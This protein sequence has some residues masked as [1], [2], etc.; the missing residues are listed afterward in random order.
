ME[1]DLL[2]AIY[3]APDDDEPRLVYADWLQER[4]DPRG[5]FI[6]LQLAGKDVD[7]QAALIAEHGPTWI[8]DLP[9]APHSVRWYRGFIGEGAPHPTAEPSDPRWRTLH[10]LVGAALLSDAVPLPA[11]RKLSI[12][13][14]GVSHLVALSRPLP[15]ETLAWD[16]RPSRGSGGLRRLGE[17]TVLPRLRRFESLDD[18]DFAGRM[19]AR[20]ARIVFS[21]PCVAAI[22]ELAV[23]N[24]LAHAHDWL[25]LE[26]LRTGPLRR[27]ELA[28]PGA[29]GWRLAL[30]RTG[31]RAWD[32]LEITAPPEPSQVWLRKSHR[33]FGEALFA[34]LAAFP[35]A[36]F[37]AARVSAAPGLWAPIERALANQVRL[38]E[39]VRV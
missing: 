7:R 8:G 10:A 18:H 22:E 17:V 1:A 2:A 31:S 9:I 25:A 35:R 32:A 37:I 21:W 6:T 27:L 24:D 11:L 26:A 12:G 15:V 30:S 19:R 23:F 33:P 34:G 4:G 38:S 3:A 5:E 28:E 39:I 13:N 29:F 14:E 16:S 20:D 36:Q